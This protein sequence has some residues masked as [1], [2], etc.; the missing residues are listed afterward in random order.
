MPLFPPS[1]CPKAWQRLLKPYVRACFN[2]A[3][4]A[5]K[6][7]FSSPAAKTQTSSYSLSLKN[8]GLHNLGSRKMSFQKSIEFTL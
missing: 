3:H 6:V 7:V 5:K 2:L 4:R 8:L 1:T